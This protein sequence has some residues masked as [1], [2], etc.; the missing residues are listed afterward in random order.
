M[1]A[2]FQ[3]QTKARHRPRLVGTPLVQGVSRILSE[4]GGPYMSDK[5]NEGIWKGDE[6]PLAEVLCKPSIFLQKDI[7]SFVQQVYVLG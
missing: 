4:S 6:C 2:V 3:I 5:A 7:S 1:S